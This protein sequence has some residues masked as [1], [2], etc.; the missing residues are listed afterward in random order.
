MTLWDDYLPFS[1]EE[2]KA[3]REK[4]THLLALVWLWVAPKPVPPWGPSHLPSFSARPDCF[5]CVGTAPAKWGDTGLQKAPPGRE[6]YHFANP[7]YCLFIL[8]N[9]FWTSYCTSRPTMNLFRVSQDLRL[10]LLWLTQTYPSFSCKWLNPTLF[11]GGHPV[12]HD[13]V[14]ANPLCQQGKC[15]LLVTCSLQYILFS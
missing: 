4:V 12:F 13:E 7:N 14:T 6:V 15:Y 5:A 1:N 10:L 9:Y 3:W 2:N 8:L 11:P